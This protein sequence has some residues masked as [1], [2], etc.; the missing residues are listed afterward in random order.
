MPE[1]DDEL[2][3]EKHEDAPQKEKEEVCE[4]ES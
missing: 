4:E 3:E 1:L 2:G